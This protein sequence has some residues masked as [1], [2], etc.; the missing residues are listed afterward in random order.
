MISENKKIY[1]L[2]SYPKSGNTW[3]RVF[4]ANY[5]NKKDIP[6]SINEINTGAIASSRVL[7]D[8]YCAVNSTDLTFTEIDLIRPDIYIELASELKEKSYNK[9][10][11][12][13]TFNSKGLPIFP[14]EISAGIIYILRNPLDV[15]ISYSNH[16]GT[17]I[18]KAI[19]LLNNGDHKLSNSEKKQ[20]TQLQQKLLTWSE[21]VKSWTEQKNIPILII[22]YEDLLSNPLE[23][24][25]KTL[26]FLNIGINTKKILQSIEFS[27]FEN[28]Q[29]QEKEQGFK[30]KPEK[31]KAFFNIGKANNWELVLTQEQIQNIINKNKEI[32]LKYNYLKN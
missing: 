25:K 30:E 28:L 22:K 14:T 32:M 24:F 8:N 2:A 10:H 12:A 18:D 13:Y 3:F 21:H 4:L 20:A 16:N 6:I 1:W 17:T 29:K 27:K 9:V 11:D 26:K 15:A 7:F 23:N 19:D 31:A 5:L